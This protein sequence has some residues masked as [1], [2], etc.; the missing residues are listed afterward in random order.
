MSIR[1]VKAT[2]ALNNSLI[3]NDELTSS[4]YSCSIHCTGSVVSVVHKKLVHNCACTLRA[5][6]LLWH[7][8]LVILF[9]IAAV[10]RKKKHF[11]FFVK[12]HSV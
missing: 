7:Y 1:S 12:A 3:I 2:L 6:C 5:I 9:L 10:N 8:N 11:T 4:L